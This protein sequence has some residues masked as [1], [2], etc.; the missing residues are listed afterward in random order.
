MNFNEAASPT[1]HRS[2][3]NP[4]RVFNN[5]QKYYHNKIII[6]KTIGGHYYIISSLGKGGF[7]ETY[8]A[9]DE[10]LPDKPPRVVKRFKPQSNDPFLLQEAKR[11]F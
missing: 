10:H 3:P 2:T 6:G 5:Y 11:L 1:V 4:I 7:G 9:H 8:L